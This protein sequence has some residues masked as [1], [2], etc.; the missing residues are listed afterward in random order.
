VYRHLNT[1]SC[2]AVCF[3]CFT[4]P[5]GISHSQRGIP[6]S[7]F[8]LQCALDALHHPQEFPT[9]SGVFPT[10][11]MCCG[12]LYILYSPTG[13]SHGQGIPHSSLVLIVYIIIGG[14]LCIFFPGVFRVFTII[15]SLALCHRV[16]ILPFLQRCFFL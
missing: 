2:A 8:V 14:H 16:I 4:T 5:T 6:H 13:I 10:V 7:S 15:L 1:F 12:V 11:L 3:R 9:V